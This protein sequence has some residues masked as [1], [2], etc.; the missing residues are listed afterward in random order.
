S[1]SQFEIDTSNAG[2]SVL[3][4]NGGAGGLQI[5]G[6]N[7]TV[8]GSGNVG[9]G[10]A[11]PATKLHISSGVLTIDGTGSGITVGGNAVFQS[12]LAVSGAGLSG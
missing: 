3:T 1:A 12:S 5:N 10:T 2:Y 9:L 7:L 6:A 8:P 4:T 11:S